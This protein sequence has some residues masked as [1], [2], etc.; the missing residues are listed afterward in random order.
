MCLP[1]ASSD[2]MFYSVNMVSGL[3]HQETVSKVQCHMRLPDLWLHIC[4]FIVVLLRMASRVSFLYVLYV[5]MFVF[6]CA[7]FV[8]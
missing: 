7:A 4:S 3:M 6:S 8:A 1:G 2:F 5:C